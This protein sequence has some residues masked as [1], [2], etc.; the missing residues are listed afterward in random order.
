MA[1]IAF[2]PQYLGDDLQLLAIFTLYFE[3]HTAANLRQS[4]RQVNQSALGSNVFSST[5]RHHM[6]AAWFVPFCAYFKRCEITLPRTGLVIHLTNHVF[7]LLLARP[8]CKAN[9]LVAS[10]RFETA[11]LPPLNL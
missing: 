1:R 9:Y 3:T 7:T 6:R 4:F 2:N 10:F 8:Q 11:E 5:L